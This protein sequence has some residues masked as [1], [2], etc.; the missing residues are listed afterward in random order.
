MSIE[1]EKNIPM[2][3]KYPFSDMEIGDSFCDSITNR[4]KISYYI[5]K[6]SKKSGSKFSIRTISETE[7]RVWR[8]E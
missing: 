3:S 1:I 5:A 2:P 7:Y 4:Y 8:I 6:E